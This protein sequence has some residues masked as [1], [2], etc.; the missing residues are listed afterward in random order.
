MLPIGN[1]M[2][3]RYN[4]EMLGELVQ[5]TRKKLKVTQKDLALSSGTGLR[6][7]IDLEKGK[8]T[9]QIGK[10]LTVLNTLGI[11]MILQPPATRPP[12]DGEHPPA[13]T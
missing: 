6:F 13:N 3:T 5:T 1:T 4:P 12:D 10:V 7:I 9:C 2:A 11:G 8:V